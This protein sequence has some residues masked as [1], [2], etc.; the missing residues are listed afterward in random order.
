M[1]AGWDPTIEHD[2]ITQSRRSRSGTGGDRMTTEVFLGRQPIVDADRQVFGYELLYRDGPDS[3]T[4]FDHPDTATRGV[5]ERVLLQW[6]MEHV[7]GDRFGMINA[8]ASLI[9]HGLH[10]AM[11]PEG[12]IIE[13]REETP[14]DDDTIAALQRARY[15]GYHFALDNVGRLGDL[16]RSQLLPLASIVKIELTTAHDA[17]IPRLIDVAR[18][19]SPGVQV[20]AEKVES[21]ADFK[22]CDEHG[23]DLFQGYYIAEPELLRRPARP[24]GARSAAALH[25]SLV[26]DGRGIDV[27]ALEWIMARDPSLAFRLLTAVN[28]NAFGLDRNV[29]SLDQAMGLLGHEKLRCLAELIASSGDTLDDDVHITRGAVR[30]H[31]AAELLA[32]TELTGS[33]VTVALL[34]TTDLLYGTPIAELLAELPVTDE[35]VGALLHGRGQLGETLDIIRACE[36]DDIAVLE[37]LAPGRSD[38]LVALHSAAVEAVAAQCTSD[39]PSN[40]VHS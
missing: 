27:G 33:G 25:D 14:F 40:H 26:D 9:V 7:V 22:R 3:A 15:D 19:R 4:T 30:A 12:M 1:K 39:D 34:S 10:R 37:E 16:E 5:M 29:R 6:G 24:A 11:P 17:E 18:E 32:G 20:V 23:F 36:D 21:V 38:E 13:V 28:A 8:S 2:S 31:M 35:I